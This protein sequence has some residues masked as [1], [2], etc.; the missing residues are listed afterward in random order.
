[1]PSIASTSSRVIAQPKGS[2]Q[3]LSP[4]ERRHKSGPGLAIVGLITTVSQTCS[5]KVLTVT[6]PTISHNATEAQ[7]S[8]LQRSG[9]AL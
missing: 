8:Y 2:S 3:L 5:R 9:E 4:M 6:T 1:M 7:G